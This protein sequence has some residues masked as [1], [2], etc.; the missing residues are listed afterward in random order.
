MLLALLLLLLVFLVF[1]LLL[2]FL[3]ALLVLI[4][5]ILLVLLLIL[6][7]VL[8]FFL[9]LLLFLLLLYYKTITNSKPFGFESS[10]SKT[11]RFLI[12]LLY[13][14]FTKCLYSS[15]AKGFCATHTILGILLHFLI[16][17]DFILSKRR[18]SQSTLRVRHTPNADN[19]QY[20]HGRPVAGW[21]RYTRSALTLPF[22]SVWVFAIM[23]LVAGGPQRH[24][25]QSSTIV[26]IPHAFSR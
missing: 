9:V 4:L 5:L 1:L 26:G 2:V 20:L 17:N 12:T 11:V 21:N 18:C 10:S 3:L 16:L 19:V 15:I 13:P 25:L 22:L 14:G 23:E 7:F 8:L 24:T 6:L